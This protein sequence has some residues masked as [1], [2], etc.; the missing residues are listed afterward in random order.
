M[1]EVRRSK[2]QPMGVHSSI[3]P[4]GRIIG[5]KTPITEGISRPERK[6]NAKGRARAVF[7]FRYFK[8]PEK[9]EKLNMPVPIEDIKRV[10]K[11]DN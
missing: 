3:K 2:T 5:G 11:R 9:I 7:E 8:I 4:E 1:N 10:R 6:I